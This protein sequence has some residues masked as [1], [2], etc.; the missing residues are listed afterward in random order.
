[1]ARLLASI[2]FDA[3]TD[4]QRVFTAAYLR[5]AYAL[6]LTA[7]EAG[8][9]VGQLLFASEGRIPAL[10]AHIEPQLAVNVGYGQYRHSVD[11]EAAE[12]H[13][14]RP[15]ASIEAWLAETR[16]WPPLILDHECDVFLS[17]FGVHPSE[18]RLE[19]GTVRL[20][21]FRGTP[22]V[23]HFNG[24][25]KYNLRAYHRYLEGE[26]EGVAYSPMNDVDVLMSRVAHYRAAFP[27]GAAWVA[28]IALT[29]ALIVCMF[30]QRMGN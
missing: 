18:A 16:A 26:A 8:H 4:D 20:P 1:V 15:C 25:S 9:P 3:R 27:T 24:P 11:A 2:V 5:Q 13:P 28:G 7:H 30:R 19:G 23:L 10:R 29:A 14:F 6:M 17:M 12:L 22:S 21:P